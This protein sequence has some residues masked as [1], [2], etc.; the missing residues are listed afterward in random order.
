M[1]ENLNVA[2]SK[3]KIKFRSGTVELRES[4]KVPDI[5][6]LYQTVVVRRQQSSDIHRKFRVELLLLCTRRR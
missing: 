2:Q 5:N 6:K 4:E 1:S 3:G